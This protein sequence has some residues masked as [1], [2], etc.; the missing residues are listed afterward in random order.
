M[1]IAFATIAGP[2]VDIDPTATV[3]IAPQRNESAARELADQMAHGLQTTLDAQDREETIAR[4]ITDRLGANW[5][6]VYGVVVLRNAA[7][8][9]FAATGDIIGVD[10][11]TVQF[12]NNRRLP[13][14]RVVAVGLD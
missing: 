4:L 3:D 1:S 13:I 9:Y 2:S 14:G 8:Q 12:A 6:R 10:T 11:L 7:G 5:G